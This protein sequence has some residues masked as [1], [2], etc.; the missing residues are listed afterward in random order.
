MAKKWD[1]LGIDA[2]IMPPYL[3]TAFKVENAEDMGSFLDYIAPWM[4]LHYPCGI[5]PITEVQD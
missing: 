2:L 4:I 1:E 3:S 5:I